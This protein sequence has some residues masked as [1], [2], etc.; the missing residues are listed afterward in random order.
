MLRRGFLT[1]L[2]VGTAAAPSIAKAVIDKPTPIDF[3]A[4]PHDVGFALTPGKEGGRVRAFD[5]W[6]AREP[7]FKGDLLWIGPDQK[8]YRIIE[9]S[10]A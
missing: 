2:A 5:D 7:F 10:N 3:D 8:V 6:T 1:K 9:T 4:Y